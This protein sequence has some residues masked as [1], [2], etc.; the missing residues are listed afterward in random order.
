MEDPVAGNGE[1]AGRYIVDY[2]RNHLLGDKNVRGAAARRAYFP[3]RDRGRGGGG[4]EGRR[5]SG[6]EKVDRALR[7][8]I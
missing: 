7:N 6:G 4:D 1:N 5:A 2:K 3:K 8:L